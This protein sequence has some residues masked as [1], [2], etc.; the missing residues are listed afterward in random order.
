MITFGYI[1]LCAVSPF[2]PC[3]KC[4]GLG[5]AL[6]TTRRGKPKRGKDCRRCRGVGRRLRT[7]RRIHNAWTRTYR[8]GTR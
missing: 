8:N 5:F 7:G 4:Q 1:S 2:G 3:R 6:E